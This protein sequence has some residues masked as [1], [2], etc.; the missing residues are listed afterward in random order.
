MAFT[1]PTVDIH[2]LLRLIPLLQ[3]WNPP[4]EDQTGIATALTDA[5]QTSDAKTVAKTYTQAL[6][7]LNSTQTQYLGRIGILEAW[8]NTTT[9]GWRKYKV[10][11]TQRVVNGDLYQMVHHL[12]KDDLSNPQ[13]QLPQLQTLLTDTQKFVIEQ[14]AVIEDNPMTPCKACQTLISSPPTFGTTGHTVV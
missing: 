13:F 1:K 6:R 14:V 4:T 12:T 11:T 9:R 8:V 5:L 10:A 2:I 3:R 7:F